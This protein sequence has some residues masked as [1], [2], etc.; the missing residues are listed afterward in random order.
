MQ[1]L[2]LMTNNGK[3][4]HA[5]SGFSICVTYHQGL[6]AILPLTPL[7]SPPD[8]RALQSHPTRTLVQPLI[9]RRQVVWLQQRANPTADISH[10]PRTRA[11]Q[12][13]HLIG[14]KQGSISRSNALG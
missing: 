8:R 2:V 1:V 13:I 6:R 10:I 3:S 12:Q 11:V 4:Q 14:E 9:L 7:R 5:G